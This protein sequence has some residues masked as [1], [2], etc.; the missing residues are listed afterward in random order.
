MLKFVGI[1][2]FARNRDGGDAA[3]ERFLRE[4][5]AVV[6]LYEVGNFGTQ[7]F[8]GFCLFVRLSH[9]NIVLT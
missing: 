9:R 1:K 7:L 2:N 4:C 5:H 6:L 8:A 3:K